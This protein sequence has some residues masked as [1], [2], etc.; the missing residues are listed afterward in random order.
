[1]LIIVRIDATFGR[2]D[3]NIISYTY[4][5]THLKDTLD[6]VCNDH[7]PIIISQQNGKPV[8]IMSLEDYNAILETFYLLKSPTNA[9]R[10]LQAKK[11]VAKSLYLKKEISIDDKAEYLLS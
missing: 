7:T 8:V 11:D 4:A 2:F 1:M 9:E 6:K 5:K 3:L 10:L